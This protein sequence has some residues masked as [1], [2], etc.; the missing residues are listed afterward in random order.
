MEQVKGTAVQDFDRPIETIE[1]A[2][3]ASPLVFSSPHSGSAYPPP[4]SPPPGSTR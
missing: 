4:F 3:L 1:P 2:R